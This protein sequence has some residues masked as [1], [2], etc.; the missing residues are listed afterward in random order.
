MSHDM[1]TAKIRAY[2]VT[3]KK[4]RYAKTPEAPLSANEAAI[5]ERLRPY[6]G[7]ALF[8][9]CETT[10]DAFLRLRF[11][12]YELHGTDDETIIS[13][14]REEEEWSLG[15]ALFPTEEQRRAVEEHRLS[16]RHV[17][18]L[19]EAGFFYDPTQVT[20]AE[21]A[22]LSQYAA[23]VP[24]A[25]HAQEEAV[26]SPWSVP[27]SRGPAYAAIE[28]PRLSLLTKEQ[29]VHRLYAWAKERE[30]LVV[31]HNLPFD[32]SRLATDVKRAS[33][34]DWHGGFSLKL[35]DCKHDRCFRHPPLHIKHLGYAKTRM[36]AQLVKGPRFV[37]DWAARNLH[38]LDTM[39]LGKA[40]LGAAY[41]LEGLGKALNLPE[42]QRKSPVDED[43]H[44]QMLTPAYLAYCR[45]D[46]LATFAAYRRERELYRQ[47]GVKK[48]MWNIYSEASLG[49]AY[50][51]ELGVPRFQ[52]SH[53]D[54]PLEVIAYSM[55][56]YYGGRAEV[57]IRLQPVEVRYLDFKSQYSTVNAL[58]RLQDALLA[59]R[60]VVAD[61][62][63]QTRT[64]LSRM[65]LDDWQRQE[66]W[67]KLRVLCKI[68]P[69]N[70]VL[71]VRA[72]YGEAGE[73]NIALAA[74][75]DGPACWYTLADVVASQLLTGKAPDL[76]A[77]LE[78]VPKGKPLTT[79]P[80]SFFGDA[81]YTIDLSK[82]DFFTR[83]IDL[84]GEFKQRAK[85]AKQAGQKDEHAY[86]DGLQQAL[87][88]LASA[89]SYGVQVELNQQDTPATRKKYPTS[90]YDVDGALHETHV[91]REEEPGPYF[92]PF[93]TFI[94][95]GGRLLL[96]IAEKLA[97][98]RGLTYAMCD[99]DSMAFA[100]PDGMERPDFL[101]RVKEIADWFTPLSPYAGKPPLFE[102]ED[103][104]DWHGQDEPLLFLG[105]SAKRYVLYNR[106]DGGLFRIRKF[107]SHGLG[108][109]S[110][111]YPDN[112]SPA[113]TPEPCEHVHDLGGPRWVYDLW[114]RAIEALERG[115]YPDG[116]K[117]VMRDGAPLYVVEDAALDVPALHQ[118]T[119]TT[120]HLYE[121][122]KRLPSVWPFSFFTVL[123][124][125][126]DEFAPMGRMAEIG[127]GSNMNIGDAT[128]LMNFYLDVGRTGTPFYAPYAKYADDLR[129]VKRCDTNAPVPDGFLPV[130]VEEAVATY[131][132]HPEWKAANPKAA[133]IMERRHLTVSGLLYIG[134]ETNEL[135]LETADETD[136]WV[137]AR[138]GAVTEYQGWRALPL[139][140]PKVKSRQAPPTDTLFRALQGYAIGD[141]MLVT[142]LPQ[143]TLYDAQ[144]GKIQPSERTKTRALAGLPML[145]KIAGWRDLPVDMLA[146]ALDMDAEQIRALRAGELKLPEERRIAL[147]EKLTALPYQDYYEQAEEARYRKAQYRQ[148]HAII[149]FLQEQG[150]IRPYRAASNG[151]IPELEEYRSLPSAVRRLHGALSMD[152]AADMVGRHFPGTGIETASD[153][154]RFLTA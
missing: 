14:Y 11:G 81:R 123:P 94:P 92:S 153:L 64:F 28:H 5:Q 29:F 33:G 104:N 136:G 139:P 91:D 78:F 131:F 4:K 67:Q 18:R 7:L 60:L 10:R 108:G 32:L 50:L 43:A 128:R 152:E 17:D 8:L 102:L 96:A 70:S 127:P 9:D 77:A 74:V 138:A 88:I 37:T 145:D 98:E 141:V 114:Y 140:E 40:L 116:R 154:L 72:E 147:L 106:L 146:A 124:G 55:A 57:H 101:L 137:Q 115:I 117:L 132:Q 13:V 86:Y 59:E 26:S 148:R 113:A 65:T 109:L 47:H 144:A 135:H 95:A 56:A 45:Q 16:Y 126:K 84:R 120:A 19:V 118:V 80:F 1:L 75:E 69:R 73:E 79:T 2:P 121:Q 15:Y 99:T 20:P 42:S 76:V 6:G 39:T 35:C 71:P 110:S 103:V 66:T 107:S 21:L 38:F 53:P 49:K 48:P 105:V 41:S 130:T 151:K 58:M 82:D 24:L 100:R 22:L 61:A 112:T 119:V 133:G 25:A 142:G 52:E 143:R 125:F 30:L 62:T 27:D 54:F 111:P 89:T 63:E 34:K 85:Q 23:S 93:G 90:F 46:V 87:K 129:E 83:V 12:F 150:Y 97:E 36:Q 149:K 44:G 31:G 51:D 3:P 134:K 122:F 68:Q